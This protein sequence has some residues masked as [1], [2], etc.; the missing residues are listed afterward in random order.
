MTGMIALVLG[1]S[2]AAR[3][4]L[5]CFLPI[6]RAIIPLAV[7]II[8]IQTVLYNGREILLQL[9]PADF[10]V[11][12]FWL[13]IRVMLRLYCIL[14]L[15]LQ[16]LLW[17]HPT[18]L[19]LVLVKAK[20]PYRYALLMGIT[21]RFFPVLEEELGSILAAQQARGMDLQNPIRRALALIPVGL[22]FCLRTLRRAHEVALAMEL[23]GY[24]YRSE[25]TFL[26]S[27]RFGPADY[28]ITTGMTLCLIA[29]FLAR[30]LLL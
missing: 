27:I 20:L 26:R 3:L 13:G 30:A 16:F 2:W 21:L 23:R 1:L 17:T 29:C 24:G 12:G 15:F 11:Q 10:H 6:T 19:S 4:D 9:G 18:D 7:G 8:L 22:P 28:A 25:R 14:L 5:R